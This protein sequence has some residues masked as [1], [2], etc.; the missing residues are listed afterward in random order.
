MHSAGERA[1]RSSGGNRTLL[2]ILAAKNRKDTAASCRKPSSMNEKR[3]TLLD[4]LTLRRNCKESPLYEASEQM[5]KLIV[6]RKAEAEGLRF[7]T[8]PKSVWMVRRCLDP[9]L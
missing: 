8:L 1:R 9:K 7:S 6:E 3:G 2:Q 5:R 4:V